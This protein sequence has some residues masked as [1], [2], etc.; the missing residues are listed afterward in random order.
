MNGKIK[1]NPRE[2]KT[3]L[4]IRFGQ[5]VREKR[6]PLFLS[7]L[8]LAGKANLHFTYLSSVERGER[9]IS[10]GN[11]AKIAI[12]LGCT[13]KDLMPEIALIDEIATNT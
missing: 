7:Q 10:L 11:I 8:Q 3:A 2:R 1:K 4:Q 13:L 5:L 9:N 12:A 6:E